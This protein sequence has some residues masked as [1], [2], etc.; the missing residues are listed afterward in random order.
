[1]LSYE[2]ADWLRLKL[3]SAINCSLVRLVLCVPEESVLVQNDS[4]QCGL[5]CRSITDLRWCFLILGL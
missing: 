1:M 2:A 4:L 3:D 5:Q